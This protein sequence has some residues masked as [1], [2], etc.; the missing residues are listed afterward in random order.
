VSLGRN[1]APNFL[2]SIL[3]NP[4]G[5]SFQFSP[6]ILQMDVPWFNASGWTNTTAGDTGWSNEIIYTTP[7]FGGLK[8]NL[9]YQFGEQAGKT[10]KNNIGGNVL[11]FN[12]PLALTA[13]Y[14]KVKVNNP[15]DIP[16]G[17]V[18]PGGNIPLPS[19]QF[20]ESQS[21]WFVGGSYDLTLAKL[22][23]TYQQTKHSDISFKD[24]TLQLGASIPVGNGA[25]LASW[26]R[27]NRSGD[28]V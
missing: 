10:G 5:D 27:T 14:Q 8:A 1:L 22:F 28:A 20:A 19:G 2:P 3:F 7:V 13:F 11:Y 9:H 24:K 25:I 15:L 17:N 4:F 12:G 23:A 6:L 18:Q 16:V 26:A 21:A